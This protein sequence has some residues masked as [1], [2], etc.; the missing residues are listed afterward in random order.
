MP[1][2]RPRPRSYPVVDPVIDPAG[3]E[4][5]V[6]DLLSLDGRPA[7]RTGRMRG[8]RGLED[9]EAELR[10]QLPDLQIPLTDHRLVAAAN[11][12]DAEGADHMREVLPQNTQ[13]GL[14]RFEKAGKVVAVHG[15]IA[16]GDI[17]RQRPLHEAPAAEA[18]AG[19]G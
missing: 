17:R 10:Q 12:A 2:Q 4:V 9:L 15:K 3:Q 6:D 13:A 16:P 14:V 11:I 1:A 18:V 8:D 7:I 19:A 5:R